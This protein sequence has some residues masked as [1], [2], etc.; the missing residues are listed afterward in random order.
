MK[1]GNKKEDKKEVD[2]DGDD[3]LLKKS[4]VIPFNSVSL[5]LDSC[6]D[7]RLVLAHCGSKLFRYAINQGYWCFLD[8]FLPLCP[9]VLLHD[10]TFRK[11]KRLK[12]DKK[13][14][15]VVDT[16]AYE[17][18]KH[19]SLLD[20]AMKHQK[21]TSI[22]TIMNAWN[23]LLS[24]SPE[25]LLSQII[26]PFNLLQK[27]ELFYLASNYPT[28]YRDF[29]CSLKLLRIH[30]TVMGEAST[31][32]LGDDKF[33]IRGVE[34]NDQLFKVQ[35]GVVIG[36][37]RDNATVGIWQQFKE[38]HCN[39]NKDDDGA[40]QVV[41]GFYL[42][43]SH[44]ASEEMISIYVDVCDKLDGDKSLFGS[45]VVVMAI[46]YAWKEY[47]RDMHLR[48]LL[49]FFA[50]AS[51]FM[52]ATL[53]YGFLTNGHISGVGWKVANY[54]LQ[55]LVLIGN[56]YFFIMEGVQMFNTDGSLL[57][58]YNKLVIDHRVSTFILK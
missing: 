53:V 39:A 42:P 8:Q 52:A 41:S 22:V 31:F 36:E 20:D 46:R 56:S 11:P 50:F 55:I 34:S 23:V 38:E 15:R 17:S 9:E 26:F 10:K 16:D 5:L 1:K 33:Y 27:T 19:F 4:K 57:D 32:P 44:A 35:D 45:P 49:M 14:G 7:S 21:V 6:K 40:D 3:S 29:I 43:L 58:K 54:V 30:D 48:S 51:I 37:W 18:T 25:D 24:T 12:E 28:E 2:V 47:G 13:A